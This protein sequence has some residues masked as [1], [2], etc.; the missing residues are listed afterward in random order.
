M[1]TKKRPKHPRA[2]GEA[3]LRS[4]ERQKWVATK[5]KYCKMYCPCSERHKAMLHITPSNPD[6][7]RNRRTFLRNHTCWVD[8]L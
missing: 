8:D 3:I 2:E 1:P 6:Y 7:F 4:V 5:G